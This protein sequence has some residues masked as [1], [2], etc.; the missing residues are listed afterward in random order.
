MDLD[1]H[2]LLFVGG[3]IPIVLVFCWCLVTHLW[4]AP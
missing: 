3:L 1:L 2:T 4:L